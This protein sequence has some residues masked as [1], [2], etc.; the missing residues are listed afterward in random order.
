MKINEVTFES[1]CM[2]GKVTFTLMIPGEKKDSYPVLWI[3]GP[4]HHKEWFEHTH[5]AEYADKY[6]IAV[7]EADS[8]ESWGG[9][10]IE[11]GH[12]LFESY[13]T[14]ELRDYVMKLI[15]MSENVKGH[16]I[17]GWSRAGYLALRIG[18]AHPDLYGTVLCNS[19]GNVDAYG[20]YK[21][22]GSMFPGLLERMFDGISTAGEF[23]SSPFHM[24]NIVEN[25]VKSN[26]V[27][28]RLIFHCGIED[29]LARIPNVRLS[30]KMKVWG[31]PHTLCMVEGSHTWE[32]I[33]I[34]IKN[35][36]EHVMDE[37]KEKRDGKE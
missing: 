17:T 19:G 15:P 24:E 33:D 22:I 35:A 8:S 28:P 12:Y 4:G 11:E 3:G 23:E 32:C 18:L 27:F 10:D 29:P 7:V 31:V 37:K 13:F 14:K 26:A 21:D 9:R 25:M 5:I 30:E 36:L 16:Y 1:V 6:G 20:L 34:S 2:A